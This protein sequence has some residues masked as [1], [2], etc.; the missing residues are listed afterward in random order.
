LFDERFGLFFLIIFIAK[1]V[2][3]I[4]GFGSTIIALTLGAMVYPIEFMLPIVVP[5]NI[6]LSTYLVTRH[7]KTINL[8]ELTRWI[9]PF[10]CIGL[11]VG[12]KILDM[13]QGRMLKIAYGAF[14]VCFAVVEL[15]RV[16]RTKGSVEAK[17]LS[18]VKA[19]IWLFAGGVIHGIY[20]SGG[21][22]VVY[23]SGKKIT[24]KGVFRSTL[25]VLW[26]VLN[27]ILLV[28]Y[29]H[30]RKMDLTSLKICFALVPSLVAGIVAGE[31]LHKRIPEQKFRILVYI[32]LIVAGAS[33]FIK[34]LML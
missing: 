31:I 10:T 14:V 2:E 32:L 8:H 29:I 1:A 6:F 23:Y 18:A 34:T 20:A 21:P 19:I 3:A 12:I 17:P 28:S 16:T 9:L 33:L 27:L 25:S 22:M 30:T 11:I 24:D 13:V 5:L 15:V 4:T 26:L 7:L